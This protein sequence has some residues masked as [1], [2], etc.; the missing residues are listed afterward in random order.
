MFDC[1]S[2]SPDQ[3]RWID[4]DEKAEEEEEEEEKEKE[5]K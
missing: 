1:F 2:H 5:E 4:K 3:V